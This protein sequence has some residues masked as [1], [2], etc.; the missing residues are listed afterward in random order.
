MAREAVREAGKKRIAVQ[1]EPDGSQLLELERTKSY[2]YSLL[3][4]EALIDLANLGQRMGVDLWSFEAPNGVSIRKAIDFLVPYTL[5]K[6]EWSWKQ[7]IP[8]E[9]ERMIPILKVAAVQ[10]NDSS[11]TVLADVLKKQLG[12]SSRLT[13]SHPLE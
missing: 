3:N 6:K 9:Y 13:F 5:G 7:I 1:I 12:N 2:N 11:Y 10:F 4:R 8:A